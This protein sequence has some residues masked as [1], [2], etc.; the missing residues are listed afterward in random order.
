MEEVGARLRAM[1]PWIRENRLVDESR[2]RP[3]VKRRMEQ[4]M[5]DPFDAFTG[6]PRTDHE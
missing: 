1:M 3:A 4:A 2:N 5:L 6:A